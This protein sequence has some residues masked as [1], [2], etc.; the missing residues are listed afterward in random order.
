MYSET[1]RLT[2]KYV[3]EHPELVTQT[4]KEIVYYLTL[5]SSLATKARNILI[6]LCSEFEID[7][8]ILSQMLF[9]EK[10][11]NEA[12]LNDKIQQ[13]RRPKKM[14]LGNKAEKILCC[15]KQAISYLDLQDKVKLGMLNKFLKKE[16]FI[17]S[18]KDALAK[19]GVGM[20]TR[21]VIYRALIPKRYKV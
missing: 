19:D 5:S 2:L 20:D 15:F 10:R 9:L 13:V 12:Y 7:K 3:Q 17:F 16:F 4:L 8:K 14:S 1:H 21:L 6:T 18:L 11:F